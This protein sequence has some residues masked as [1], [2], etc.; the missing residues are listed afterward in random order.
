FKGIP[1]FRDTR[2]AML[3]TESVEELFRLFDSITPPENSL[4]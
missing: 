1:N 2:I 4:L 3:R